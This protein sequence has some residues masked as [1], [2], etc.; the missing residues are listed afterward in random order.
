MKHALITGVSKGIGK[1][2]AETLHLEGYSIFG[3]YKWSQE[4][5]EEQVLAE[6][7]ARRLPNLTLIPCDLANRESFDVIAKVIADMKLDSIV[8]NA[9]EFLD[10]SWSE[11]REDAWDRSIAVNME[12]PI[13]L[14]KRLE[15][16]LQDGSSIVL[17]GST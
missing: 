6:E 17:I 2:I 5:Q 15:N 1:T 3:V 14:T 9:G 16:N 7:V 12:A 10:N 13:L 8:H 11:F 4:Y